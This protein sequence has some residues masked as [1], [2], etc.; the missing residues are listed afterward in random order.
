MNELKR[1]AGV[2]PEMRFSST[3]EAA[4]VELAHE[5]ADEL[6]PAARGRRRELV[7]ERE[8]SATAARAQHVELGREATRR[9]ARRL[10]RD[11]TRSA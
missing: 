10:A 6:V 4:A 2:W 11:S 8:V 7:E 5:R 1:Q 9:G 3:V